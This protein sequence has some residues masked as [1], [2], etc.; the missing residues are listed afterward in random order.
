MTPTT[1][2]GVAGR[3]LEDDGAARVDILIF[4]ALWFVLVVIF[5]GIRRHR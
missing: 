3:V 5:E 4:L 2:A 1:F